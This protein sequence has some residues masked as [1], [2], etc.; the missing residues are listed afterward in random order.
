M[1]V[2]RVLARNRAIQ[3]CEGVV[4][5]ARDVH[6]SGFSMTAKS[7]VDENMR[8]RNDIKQEPVLKTN[9][10][11]IQPSHPLPPSR[12]PQLQLPTTIIRLS[13]DAIKDER[14]PKQVD[15]QYAFLLQ[16]TTDTSRRF[17]APELER[18]LCFEPIFAIRRH[19]GCKLLRRKRHLQSLVN[20][21]VD[22]PAGKA[23]WI[24]W[25]DCPWDLIDRDVQSRE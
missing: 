19:Q 9:T 3:E 12:R 25:V 4:S 20:G 22:V 10:N 18:L 13:A 16:T 8:E 11:D 7:D 2:M 6:S 17:L 5:R 24:P 14:L 15:A 21:I 1:G 23:T